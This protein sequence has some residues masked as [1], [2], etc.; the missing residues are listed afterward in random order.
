MAATSNFVLGK[1]P[2]YLLP[3]FLVVL[4]W[5]SLNCYGFGT[6]GFD[7]H[8]K[9]SDPVRDIIGYDEVPQKG[10]VDYYKVL[11]H[12]DHLIK[13]RHL[14]SDDQTTPLAFYPGNETIQLGGV[15][16]YL[17]YAN[18]SVGTPSSSYLVALDTGSDLFWLP[19]DCT[20]CVGGVRSRDG[21]VREFNIF[22]PNTSSTSKKVSC[23][24]T[25]CDLRR[26]C[27]S[28]TS[29]CPYQ[30]KYLS[31]GTSSTGYLV[32]DVLH[33]ITDDAKLKG[34]KAPITFGCGTVQTGSFLEGAAPNGLIGLGIE[35]ISV[36]SIL[37][38]EGYTSNSFSM[39]F[40]H[41]GVGRIRFG[42]KGSLD[43]GE[44]PFSIRE[45]HPTY[46]VTITQINVGGTDANLE[47]SA[48]F[49]SGTSF[50]Y[51]NDPA[52]TLISESFNKMANEDRHSS[53][54]SIPFEYCYDLRPNQTS[55]E[56]PA[57]NFTMKGGH[58]YAV[59]DSVVVVS[60]R[61][62]LIYCL[63]VVKSENVNIIGQNFMTGYRITFDREKLVLGWKDSNCFKEEETATLPV[64]PSGSPAIS[65]A[66]TLSPEA[67][68]GSVNNSIKPEA[69]PPRNHSSK[70]NSFSFMFILLITCPLFVIV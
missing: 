58:I 12:G 48:I 24:S 23:N 8:H 2:V 1:V 31:N 46:N 33:L 14:T 45:T 17:H 38:K 15:F 13:A 21:N 41:E 57:L 11:V 18:I 43:Q 61:G 47:F 19:C 64:K 54:S 36:P 3:L 70:L 63:G 60:E 65:P 10:T 51:L 55:F 4:G 52:Y 62:A 35:D 40:G 25:L 39:C 16:G 53:N 9:F 27:P 32:E 69:A 20:S 6:F 59:K 44:T 50:T 42:D 37:A 5:G 34:V 67:T 22:S 7:I 66:G 49:D 29:T 28:E 68:S 26:Q 56:Y 30:I